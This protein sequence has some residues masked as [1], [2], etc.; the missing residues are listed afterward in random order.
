MKS[1][2]ARVGGETRDD[3]LRFLGQCLRGE[4]VVVDLAVVRTNAVLHGA[5]KFAREI[6]LGAVREMTAVVEAHAEDGVARLDQ[7]EI[8]RGVG[9]RAR[10]RLHVGVVG[11]EEFLGAVDGELLGDVDELATAVITLARI[12]FGVLVGEYRALRFQHARTGVVLRGDQ[13][14]V[15]F[16]ALAFVL[17]GG[18]EFGVK[19]TDGHRGTEHG[20]GLAGSTSGGREL[21]WMCRGVWRKTEYSISSCLVAGPAWRR[22]DKSLHD[23]RP[24]LREIDAV[25]A[26]AAG[27]EHAPMAQLLGQRGQIARRARVGLRA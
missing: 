9:L 19:T 2:Y 20:K 16:L 15:I 26:A 17:E 12:T 23:P 11:A 21:Y 27:A 8:G 4:R 18:I 24:G 25:V 1:R 13:L 14:D 7:R 22:I 10:V 6:H 5:E 3:H